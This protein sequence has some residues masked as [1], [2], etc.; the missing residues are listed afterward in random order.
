MRWRL[1]EARQT[2]QTQGA[3]FGKVLPGSASDA[4]LPY[5]TASSSP[6][7][8][9]ETY[10]APKDEAGQDEAM[11]ETGAAGIAVR[12]QG[13]RG[14]GAGPDAVPDRV[15][16]PDVQD[17]AVGGVVERVAAHVVAGLEDGGDH[18][19]VDRVGQRWQLVPDDLGGQLHGLAAPGVLDRVAVAAPAHDQLGDQRGDRLEH[20]DVGG[21]GV[22]LEHAEALGPVQQRQPDG[23]VRSGHL[24][25]RERLTGRGA[26][27][28]HRRA[29]R[30]RFGAPQR[31]QLQLRVVDQQHPRRRGLQQRGRLV[32][33]GGQVLGPSPMPQAQQPAHGFHRLGHEHHHA[34]PW[35]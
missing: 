29:G 12:V 2:E 30:L 28:H 32:Q 21:P 3:S 22:H 8:A 27:D 5:D 33:Q 7:L 34:P 13:Q 31:E 9:P 4:I 6:P 18:R 20:V 26:V 10:E 17:V 19:P 24:G 1:A 15:E 16:Q 11:V 14:Q 25:R 35:P 23:L